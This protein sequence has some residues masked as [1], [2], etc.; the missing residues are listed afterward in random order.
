MSEYRQSAPTPEQAWENFGRLD[1]V[2][3][4][5]G[6][7][8]LIG[9]SPD[10][11]S[12]QQVCWLLGRDEPECNRRFEVADWKQG[13]FVQ[14]TREP[15]NGTTYRPYPTMLS[16]DDAPARRELHVVTTGDRTRAIVST[17]LPDPRS[18][19]FVRQPFGTAGD[20]YDPDPN[21]PHCTPRVSGLL[22]IGVG[23]K[24]VYGHR[25]THVNYNL[26]TRGGYAAVNEYPL[27]TYAAPGVALA[28]HSYDHSAG[29]PEPFTG[30]PYPLP[31]FDTAEATRDFWWEQLPDKQRV[32]IAVVAIEGS[33]RSYAVRNAA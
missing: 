15:E 12:Y 26:L 20:L 5:L 3:H 10:G 28:A 8:V 4:Y 18:G 2:R 27:H 30:Q 29:A 16:Y 23:V 33:R 9:I 24:N 31:L 1:M 13:Q 22:D 21:D 14:T 17:M 19:R 25:E 11:T 32:A 7:T 6:N